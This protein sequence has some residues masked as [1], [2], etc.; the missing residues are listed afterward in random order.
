MIFM[1]FF[2]LVGPSQGYNR[3]ALSSTNLINASFDHLYLEEADFS[4]SDMMGV[5]FR[6]SKVLQTNFSSSL[7]SLSNFQGADVSKSIFTNAKMQRAAFQNAILFQ[8]KMNNAD[9]GSTNFQF[10]KAI[11]ANFSGSEMSNADFQYA[12]LYYAQMDEIS[13]R[14]ADFYLAKAMGA[15]FTRAYLSDCRFQWADLREASFKYAVLFGTSFE[16]ANVYNVDFTGANL[17]GVQ[18]TAGQLDLVLSIT[19]ATLPDS[20][21]GKNK[22]LV[23]NSQAQCSDINGTI[24]DWITNGNVLTIGNPL[25]DDCAFQAGAIN[26]TLQQTIDIRRY[27]G[28]IKTG[29]R[30]VYIEMQDKTTAILDPSVYM[31]V[32]FFD[33]QNIEIA[34]ESKLELIIGRRK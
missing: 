10:V 17:V 21:K 12:E 26:T 4:L 5:S 34:G 20:S 3:L 32:R 31:L 15:D 27:Q 24:S 6:S 13:A 14:S 1:S 29:Q 33:A 11:E 25:S 23:K 2:S 19:N 8:T 7:L 30:N 28:L 18:I 16:N 9:I 22:N